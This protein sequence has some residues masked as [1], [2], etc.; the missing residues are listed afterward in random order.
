MRF[1]FRVVSAGLLACVLL[2]LVQAIVYTP[3]SVYI[4]DPSGVLD[5]TAIHRAT[6]KI[7]YEIGIYTG[8]F[9]DSESLLSTVASQHIVES[10]T[11]VIVFEIDLLHLQLA[12]AHSPDVLLTDRQRAAI[13]EAFDSTL[14]SQSF[15][16]A[17]ISALA[18]LKQETLAPSLV[19]VLLNCV[20]F[21][22]C[23]LIA[24]CVCNTCASR[25]STTDE[26]SHMKNCARE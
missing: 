16:A 23:T 4:D 7:P 20:V 14:S 11:G 3:K 10:A 15:S 22:E 21:I 17:L 9:A 12:I 8:F 18:V 19:E 5:Q 13:N 24:S 25:D 2:V 6:N 26:H 1:S